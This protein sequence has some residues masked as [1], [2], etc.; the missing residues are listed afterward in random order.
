MPRGARLDGRRFPA[1]S[2]QMEVAHNGLF[3]HCRSV[4]STKREIVRAVKRGK[5]NLE[6][7][8]I[9]RGLGSP[10]PGENRRGEWRRANETL[11]PYG[12][13]CAAGLGTLKGGGEGESCAGEKIVYVRLV[14]EGSARGKERHETERFLGLA[15]TFS[16]WVSRC[17]CLSFL[18]P[19]S[20]P[21]R[22]IFR[23][24]IPLPPPPPLPKFTSVP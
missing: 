24:Q 15:G 19:S 23:S 17:T 1:R 16:R 6:G 11:V 13:C 10:P 2:K 9:G 7:S 21:P 12:R 3:S 22:L 4:H 8:R 14:A 5:E 20:D 18:S